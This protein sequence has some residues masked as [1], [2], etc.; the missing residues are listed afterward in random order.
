MLSKTKEISRVIIFGVLGFL[1][2]SSVLAQGSLSVVG[3]WET[4]DG[5]TKKP[6]SIIQILPKGSVY[7]GKIIKTFDNTSE[8]KL[9]RCVACRD[10]RK[11]QPI[12][13]LNII[14]NMQCVSNYCHGGTILD[15]RDGKIY[16]AT[17]RLINNGQQLKVRGYV[18]VSLFGKTVV[19]NRYQ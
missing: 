1:F 8:K 15:P 5:K 6:S 11:N 19:W 9:N 3:K 7:I 10:N 14:E 13:G 16:K 12:V 18:G 17:M 2:S 4:I